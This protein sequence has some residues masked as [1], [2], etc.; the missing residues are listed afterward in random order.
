MNYQFD[1]RLRDEGITCIACHVRAHARFGPPVSERPPVEIWRGTGH[2]GANESTVYQSSDFCSACH[3]FADGNRRMNGGLLQDTFQEW[4]SSPQAR[5]GQTCQTCHM[6]D[7]SHRWLGIHDPSTVLSAIDVQVSLPDST[8]NTVAV[9]EV[10]NV[11]AGHHLPTYVTPKIFVNAVLV[12]AGDKPLEG[13][14][15][16][17]AI[18]RE[19]ILN[20]QESRELYDSRIPAGGVWSWPYAIRT[21]DR[22]L[23]VE[24]SL[25]VF[26][27][28]FYARFFEDYER[29]GLSDDA[30][31]AIRVAGMRS[32]QSN[33]VAF[34]ETFRFRPVSDR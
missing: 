17:R 28:H 4:Q 7:R 2:G 19:I 13:S 14:R 29:S 11:G 24:I 6:P 1:A 33:Y 10:R 8:G 3:Q 23:G 5:D 16:T 34:R 31:E 30:A 26:P 22:A 27:D 12:D 32:S 9:I 15:E 18:G 21:D 20:S 25:E